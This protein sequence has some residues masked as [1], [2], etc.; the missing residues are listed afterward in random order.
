MH[1]TCR[2]SLSL[3]AVAGGLLFAGGADAQ[4]IVAI[5]NGAPISSMDVQSRASLM[6]LGG[7]PAPEQ[8]MVVDALI[9]ERLKMLEARRV[10]FLPADS[11]VEEAYGNI[12]G[13]MK[14]NSEQFTKALATRGVQSVTLK[15]RLKAEIGWSRFV[16]EK[17]RITSQVQEQDVIAAFSSKSDKEKTDV[18]KGMTFRLASILFVFPKAA[19]AE[20]VKRRQAE[21][22]ALRTK[23]K[24]CDTGFAMAKA[25]RDVAVRPLLTRSSTG[26]SPRVREV[27]DATAVGS[28]TQ[29]EK[30]EDGIELF[31]V[32]EKKEESGNLALQ[33]VVRDEMNQ[34]NLQVEA[35]RYINDLRARAIIEYR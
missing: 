19:G 31:A 14:M 28:L 32:C 17:F 21:A 26:M 16:R 12:A 29:P 35:R 27:L 18:K 25:I 20:V 9:E 6:K 30:A 33:A 13:T 10:G 1:R 5:V 3:I 15:S 8:R 7:G 23:F 22:D 11:E 4:S 2:T 24:D 34:E